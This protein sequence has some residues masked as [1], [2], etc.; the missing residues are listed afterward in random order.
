MNLKSAFDLGPYDVV[1]G[2]MHGM[3]ANLVPMGCGV[4]FD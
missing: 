1:G 3:E 4:K 2:A